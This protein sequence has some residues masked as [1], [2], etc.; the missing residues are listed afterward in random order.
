MV[1]PIPVCVFCVFL[2]FSE[3]HLGGQGE[4]YREREREREREGQREIE[5]W[6]GRPITASSDVGFDIAFPKDSSQFS[7]A[8]HPRWP[9]SL[10]LRNGLHEKDK[11][12]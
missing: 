12:T 3:G 4:I 7:G 9:R 6:L 1:S 5:F 10:G 2:C 11:K 8:W